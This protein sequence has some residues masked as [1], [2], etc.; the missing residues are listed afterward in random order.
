MVSSPVVVEE[1]GDDSESAGVIRLAAEKADVEEGIAYAL[2]PEEREQELEEMT[3]PRKAAMLVTNI[4]F[5]VINLV[6]CI[7]SVG[8]DMGKDKYNEE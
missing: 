6:A 5:I 4:I 7:L 2:S 8:F 1:I 3:R